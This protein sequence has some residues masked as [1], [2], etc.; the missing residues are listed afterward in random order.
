MS[1]LN[2]FSEDLYE[3][4]STIDRLPILTPFSL[5]ILA[6]ERKTQG[7]TWQLKRTK[8]KENV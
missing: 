8:K 1:S 5:S 4:K 3:S 6:R 7:G 2:F